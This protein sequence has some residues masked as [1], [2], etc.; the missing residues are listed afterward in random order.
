ML[1]MYLWER[2]RV[3]PESNFRTTDKVVQRSATLRMHS[4]E[5]KFSEMFHNRYFLINTYGKSYILWLPFE[6]SQ[7][8]S[9]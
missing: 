4:E 7:C 8:E 3:S 6:G 2:S 5:D 1:G 9:N